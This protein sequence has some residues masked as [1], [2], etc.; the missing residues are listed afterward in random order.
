[1]VER[2]VSELFS[3]AK[4]P[5][6]RVGNGLNSREIGEPAIGCGLAFYFLGCRAV[7]FRN[8]STQERPV[9]ANPA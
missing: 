9:D 5:L 2:V 8:A 7:K 3:T 6:L 4:L 1:M